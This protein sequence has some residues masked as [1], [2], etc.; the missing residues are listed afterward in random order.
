MKVGELTEKMVHDL[1]QVVCAMQWQPLPCDMHCEAMRIVLPAAARHC[2]SMGL[3]RQVSDVILKRV[4][5]LYITRGDDKLWESW[6]AAFAH[7]S[8][9]RSNLNRFCS[10]QKKSKLDSLLFQLRTRRNKARPLPV[11]FGKEEGSGQFAWPRSVPPSP[12][13][14]VIDQFLYHLAV[15][16]MDISIFDGFIGIYKN[17]LKLR[18]A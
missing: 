10:I 13:Q 7:V 5:H 16:A 11:L 3:A 9:D 1:W 17:K 4:K 18:C 6:N 14:G 2:G 12:W 8:W 15:E